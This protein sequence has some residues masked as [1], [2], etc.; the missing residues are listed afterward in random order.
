ML[1]W[2]AKRPKM[3]KGKTL[4]HLGDEVPAGYFTDAEIAD[5][6]ERGKIKKIEPKE[7]VIDKAPAVKAEP[8]PAQKVDLTK[9]EKPKEESIEK[10]KSSSDGEPRSSFGSKRKKRG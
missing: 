7:V 6:V 5:F 8:K 10:P 9:A 3:R 2:N 1:I 4:F